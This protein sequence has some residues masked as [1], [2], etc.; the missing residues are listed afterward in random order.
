M[1]P[2]P[3]VSTILASSTAQVG[4][5]T[6]WLIPLLA[7]VIGLSVAGIVLVAVKRGVM[8]GVKRMSGGRRRGRGRRR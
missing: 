8:A 2:L 4:D 5:L 1:I 3:S 6:T 7:L